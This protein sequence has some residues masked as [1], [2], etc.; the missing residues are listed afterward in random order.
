LAVHWL[1]DGGQHR[2]RLYDIYYAVQNRPA[3][4]DWDKCLEVV[5]SDAAEVGDHRDRAR[6]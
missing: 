3:D 4:F 6:T 5:S 2:E 1:N